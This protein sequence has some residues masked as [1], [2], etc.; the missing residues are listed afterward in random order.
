M[1]K[2][3]PS[4][5]SPAAV[6]RAVRQ[7][8]QELRATIQA[9]DLVCSGTLTTRTKVC[10]QPTCRC[11][12]DPA[13]RHGPYHEWTRRTGGKLLHS[14]VSSAQAELLARGIANYREIQRLLRL[15]EQ[16]S[17]RE[18]LNQKSAKD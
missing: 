7:R 5:R 8:S 13:A 4:P 6:R 18:V 2:S 14:V 1:P 3:I 15:W 17:A 16:H 11:A 9:M 10:G 12:S